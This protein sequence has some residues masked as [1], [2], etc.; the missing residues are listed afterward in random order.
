MKNNIN[1]SILY[2]R[3][4][5]KI[6]DNNSQVKSNEFSFSFQKYNDRFFTL[7]SHLKIIYID[8]ILNNNSILNYE[9]MEGLSEGSNFVWG[10]KLQKKLKNSLQIDLIYDGRSSKTSEVKHVGN[11]GVTAFF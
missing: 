1:F 8:A 3:Q 6:S 4:N 2:I 11:I 7:Q 10:I 5:K 9:L